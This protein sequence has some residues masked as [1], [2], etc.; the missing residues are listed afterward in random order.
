MPTPEITTT[1]YRAWWTGN[2]LNETDLGQENTIV[3]NWT[4]ERKVTGQPVGSLSHSTVYFSEDQLREA[5]VQGAIPAIG[6]RYVD[7]YGS[8][9]RQ[10]M[11]Y[12]TLVARSMTSAA[13]GRANVQLTWLAPF[14]TSARWYPTNPGP[15]ATEAIAYDLSV[16]YQ[17]AYRSTTLFVGGWATVPPATSDSTA[18]D[19]GGT[20]IFPGFGGSP[21]QTEQLRIRIRRVVDHK[22]LPA[23]QLAAYFAPMANTLNDTAFMAGT[24]TLDNP[25]GSGTINVTLPGFARGTVLLESFNLVKTQGQ[26]GEAV[27][28]FVH[29]PDFFFHDQYPQLD[30]D[31]QPMRNGTALTDIRWRRVPRPYMEHNR[32]F[33]DQSTYTGGAWAPTSNSGYLKLAQQGWWGNL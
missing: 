19:I 16:D 29:E 14:H 31:G 18:S 22:Y 28:D 13:N 27:F 5:T 2:T 15:T 26:Y 21:Y 23:S 6:Q 20:F 3:E 1:N 4:L 12:A 11:A 7:W 30:A 25:S 33:F 8:N 24:L 9:A 10:W 32:V 17:T